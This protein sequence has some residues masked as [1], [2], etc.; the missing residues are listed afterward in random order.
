MFNAFPYL[1]VLFVACDEPPMKKLT[2]SEKEM[3][4]E[5]AKQLKG[6]Q[7]RLHMVRVVKALGWGG[8]DY[9]RRILKRVK[10]STV[11]KAPGNRRNLRAFSRPQPGSECRRDRLTAVDRC[12]GDHALGLVLA[13]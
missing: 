5:T 10:K 13:G 2:A 4:N 12:Q 1:N 6:G 11:E 8:Q 7:K 9:A 3:Y